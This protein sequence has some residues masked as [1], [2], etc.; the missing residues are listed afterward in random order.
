MDFI[1]L[2]K[3]EGY[4]PLSYELNNILG[5]KATAVFTILIQKYLYVK[6]QGKL[7][8]GK[9]Y[10]SEKDIE[11]KT[12]IGP[13]EQSAIIE[14]LS[15]RGLLTCKKRGYRFFKIYEDKVLALFNS[16]SDNDVILS[17]DILDKLK[18]LYGRSVPVYTQ[19]KL[20]DIIDDEDVI[21][22]AIELAFE[23]SSKSISYI[24][25]ILRDWKEKELTTLDK[26]HIYL[27]SSDETGKT[28][29]SKDLKAINEI[30]S[31][32]QKCFKANN[33]LDADIA[34][35]LYIEINKN[36]SFSV[37]I[38]EK[39]FKKAYDDNIGVNEL[40]KD[41]EYYIYSAYGYR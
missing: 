41:I 8:N 7:N 36:K 33:L 20:K 10:C 22:K 15:N 4:I 19:K 17:L 35:K 5:L 21:R 38:I 11:S 28:L 3:K 32:Y 27:N 6:S 14:N 39:I 25:A 24:F 13:E 37:D 23:H 12:G 29:S 40:L 1:K 2:I 16:I 30:R 26:V 34:L 18:E 9:F 31:S